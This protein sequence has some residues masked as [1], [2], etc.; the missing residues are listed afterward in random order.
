MAEHYE[1]VKQAD[2]I[3]RRSDKFDADR[4]ARAIAL[5]GSHGLWSLAQI[6]AIS[7]AGMHEVRRA[8]TKKDST[9]GRFNPATL[10]WILEEFDLRGRQD[11]N[12][13]L[14][15]KIVDEGT[16]VVMLARILGVSIPSIRSQVRRGHARMEVGDV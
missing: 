1:A 3:Y 16:S 5:L 12:D 13:L 10:T 7:G 11:T 14:T 15:T 8:V 9:G 4:R 6:S 2:E